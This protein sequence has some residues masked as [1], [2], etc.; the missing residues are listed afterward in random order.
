MISLLVRIV[1]LWSVPV[2]YLTA[3]IVRGLSIDGISNLDNRGL[4]DC[5]RLQLFSF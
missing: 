5:D 3:W 4:V 1:T 2:T